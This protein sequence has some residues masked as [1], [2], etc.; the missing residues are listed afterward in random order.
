MARATF[1]MS[2]PA[3]QAGG[4]VFLDWLAGFG[5]ELRRIWPKRSQTVSEA[6]RMMSERAKAARLASEATIAER[7]AAFHAQLKAEYDG[8]WPIKVVPR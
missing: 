2:A 5:V 4:A 1:P 7:K 6:A 3:S 8:G